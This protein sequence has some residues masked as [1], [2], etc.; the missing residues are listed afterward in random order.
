MSPAPRIAFVACSFE[1]I[2]SSLLL[3]CRRPMACPSSCSNAHCRL[4]SKSINADI[5][6]TAGTSWHIN[7]FGLRGHQLKPTEHGM[8]Q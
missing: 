4:Y 8:N 1:N 3:E 5:H 7:R 2:M 6:F